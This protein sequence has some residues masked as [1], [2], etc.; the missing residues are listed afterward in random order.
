M[1]TAGVEGPCWGRLTSSPPLQ[2]AAC[3]FGGGDAQGPGVGG[4]GKV[5]DSRVSTNV[6]N[7]N[8][9]PPCLRPRPSQHWPAGPLGMAGRS[10]SNSSFFEG[11]SRTGLPAAVRVGMGVG[12]HQVGV[13]SAVGPDHLDWRH[14]GVL[15]SGL[16]APAPTAS[17]GP[18]L[19]T[20]GAGTPGYRPLSHVSGAGADSSVCPSSICSR[21]GGNA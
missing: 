19:R 3:R 14:V 11:R 16:L 21:P 2:P 6:R 15:Q 7:G 10:P 20:L 12:V 4:R 18:Y 17:R 5:L 13:A 1:A 9:L 8:C